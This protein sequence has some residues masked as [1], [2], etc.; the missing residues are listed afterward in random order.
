[1]AAYFGLLILSVLGSISLSM[2]WK[3][4][5][6]TRSTP[7]F[8]NC[9][10][11]PSDAKDRRGAL[12]ATLGTLLERVPSGGLDITARTAGN[13]VVERALVRV[14][15]SLEEASPYRPLKESDVFPGMVTQ[16]IG[17]VNRPRHGC[18]ASEDRD[19]TKKKLTRR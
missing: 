14:R 15:R 19:S 6:N 16:M 1:L 12:Y 10:A 9:R 2:V 5:G 4:Q 11:R 3:T 17:V 18:D 13:A 7:C 8:S